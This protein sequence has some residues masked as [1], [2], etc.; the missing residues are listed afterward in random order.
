MQLNE[1][2]EHLKDLRDEGHGEK[3][4]MF[5]YGSGDYWR[6]VVAVKAET[7]EPAMVK[8]TD[9]HSKYKVLE[10]TDEDSDE[11]KPEGIEVILIG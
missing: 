6:T 9:Y 8:W 10:S 1:F 5:G 4:V 11:E 2:I 3:E 7:A